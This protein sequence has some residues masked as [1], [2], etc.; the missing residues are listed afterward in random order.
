MTIR[1]FTEANGCQSYPGFTLIELLV[2]VS[3]IALL[4]AL[5]LPALNKA[6]ESARRT[7]C[8][9]QLHQIGLALH[10]YSLDSKDY[11]PST[12]DHRGAT[13]HVYGRHDHIMERMWDYGW[14]L[15][16]FSCPSAAYR[17][18]FRFFGNGAPLV[19]TYFYNGGRGDDTK[20]WEGYGQNYGKLAD[21]KRPVLRISDASSPTDTSL[22]TD[23]FRSQKPKDV[24]GT[25]VRYLDGSS[26]VHAYVAGNHLNGT[27][28]L[29]RSAGLNVLTVD[30]SV[31]WK[32]SADAI[33]RCGRQYHY[34]YW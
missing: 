32:A 2:V 14:S 6:R 29:L 23:L 9:S 18:K 11:Y 13:N 8:A 26:G 5:L 12:T 20:G 15:A 16:V 19:T 28:P 25:Y 33:Y 34:M 24:Q 10:Q 22:M 21:N 31:R 4:V 3:I 1:R 30:Q 7:A 17:A 27:D